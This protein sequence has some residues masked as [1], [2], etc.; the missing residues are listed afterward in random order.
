MSRRIDSEILERTF[1]D[2]KDLFLNDDNFATAYQN[3][4]Q[5]RNDLQNAATTPLRH[6]NPLPPHMETDPATKLEYDEWYEIMSPLVDAKYIDT[7][8]TWLSAPWLTAEFYLYRRLMEAFDYFNPQSLTYR[9]DPFLSQKQAGLTSSLATAEPILKQIESLPQKSPKD[10]LALAAAFAL[11]GNK[12]DLSIWPADDMEN[13]PGM[14]QDILKSANDNLLHD[15]TNV[16]VQRGQALLEMGGGNVDIVVDNAGFELIMDLAL[17]DYLIASG[18]AKTF[19][20]QLKSHPTFVSDA[21]EADLRSHIEYYV[22][23]DSDESPNCRAAGVRWTEYL[24]SGKWIC[25]EH[26]FWVQPT[27]MWDMPTDLRKDMT[28]RCDLAFIKG[29][30]NYRRLLGD[31]EWDYSAPFEDVVGSYFPCNVCALRTLKAEIG[32][33]MVKEKWEKAQ[34]TDENWL[35]NGRFGVVHFGDGVAVK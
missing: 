19:T 4:L 2:N 30:A 17:A 13:I 7:P 8:E 9:H 21:M 1:L 14:F 26:S 18:I 31:L 3:F 23:A 10:G 29:D 35:V 11:W 24:E 15:D 33:G 20:F 27:P 12:M 34:A 28:S 5:L 25:N 6:L 16:L 32:C 22:A